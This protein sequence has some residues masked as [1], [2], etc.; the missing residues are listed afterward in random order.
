MH[1]TSDSG[2]PVV[3][4]CYET[5][6]SKLS[7]W[8][9]TRLIPSSWEERYHALV[10]ARKT[11]GPTRNRLVNP[12]AVDEGRFDSQ[13]IGPWTMWAHDGSAD[14]MVV[15]QDWGTATNLWE[16]SELDKP[17]LVTNTRLQG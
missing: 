1:G 6:S 11:F 14:L 9:V 16:T 4:C 15:G 12:A 17:K 10:A 13:Q 8:V 2:D 7:R 3:V 5:A